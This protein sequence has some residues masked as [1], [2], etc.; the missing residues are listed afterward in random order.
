MRQLGRQMPRMEVKKV[1]KFLV[2]HQKSLCVPPQPPRRPRHSLVL[3]AANGFGNMAVDSV[4][5]AIEPGSDEEAALLGL[6]IANYERF[7]SM[8]AGS[9]T[10]AQ[11]EATSAGVVGWAADSGDPAGGP[12]REG[13]P[14]AA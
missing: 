9:A 8:P 1:I 4:A 7:H 6:A 13:V 12:P 2:G 10:A 11:V 5:P 3:S 14:G